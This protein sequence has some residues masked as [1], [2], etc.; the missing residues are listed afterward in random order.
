M[1]TIE[2][3]RDKLAN[4]IN[5]ELSNIPLA[6][7][8]HIRNEVGPGTDIIHALDM[9]LRERGSVPSPSSW[10]SVIMYTDESTKN[11]THAFKIAMVV[12]IEKADRY[13]LSH[14]QR[15]VPG[16]A[17]VDYVVLYL[18]TN[19]TIELIKST[20]AKL[21]YEEITRRFAEQ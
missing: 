2:D 4:E 16:K 20:C 15:R 3:E 10:Q 11:D 8:R 21:I 7:E 1:K 17:Y 19:N 5:N 18:V 6:V 13:E 12:S 14:R 9:Y